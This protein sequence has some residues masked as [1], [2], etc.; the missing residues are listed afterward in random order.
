MTATCNG[1]NVISCTLTEPRV[2]VWSAMVDVDADAAIT[3][4]VSLVIDGVTW[5]G[6]VVKGD[7]HAGRVHL[8]LVGGAGK[9][10]KVLEVK[11][12][13]GV[14]LG[15]VVT[16]IMRETGESLSSDT[17][18]AVRGH[19]VARWTRTKGPASITL[20]KVADELGLVWRVQRDGTVWLGA[21]KWAESKTAHDEIDRTPGRDA[22]V[23]APEAPHVAPGQSFGGRRVSRV[24]TSTENGG[25]LRQEILYES[26]NGGSRVAEDIAAI[27]DQRTADKIDYSRLY[28]SKVLSQSADGTLEIIP[29]AKQLR[30]NGL[31]GV[32][33]RHGIPG[34][35][36]RVPAGGKVLLF[37]EAGDPKLPAAALWPDGSSCTEV[38]IRTPKLI[39]DG[40]I[41]CTGEIT[42]HSALPAT[43]VR[44]G[45]HIHPAATGPTD[46]PTPGMPP[47]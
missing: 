2:G 36:V 12:Y 27:V 18:P 44:L 45:R 34:V 47:T 20:K 21:D 26:A 4:K 1:K 5:T 39:V 42:A 33:I 19:Q 17:D 13:R 43:R 41:E 38:R 3:G 23:I 25:G 29:D 7:H 37:F 6:I 40:D 35:T 8:Q 28:P 10:G 30:G 22:V 31:T 32:P 14:N 16:D 46:V 24:T 11:H 15:A 9:L